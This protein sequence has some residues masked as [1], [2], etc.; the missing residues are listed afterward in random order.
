[1]KKLLF[2]YA[3]LS[4]L[5]TSP[6]S[7]MDLFKNFSATSF[8]VPRFSLL[9]FSAPKISVPSVTSGDVKQFMM[10]NAFMGVCAGGALG[11][12]AWYA[13]KPLNL[14][15]TSQKS[16]LVQKV[17]MP[18]AFGL[19]SFGGY[20]AMRNGFATANTLWSATAVGAF[21]SAAQWRQQRNISSVLSTQLGVLDSTVVDL[22]NTKKELTAPV[23]AL[24]E[25]EDS[26]VADYEH[27]KVTLERMVYAAALDEII[28]GKNNPVIKPIVTITVNN[29]EKSFVFEFNEETSY[30]HLFGV[31]LVEDFLK[32][33]PEL[34]EDY[35]FEQGLSADVSLNLTELPRRHIRR[36]SFSGFDRREKSE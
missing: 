4:A 18:V 11:L 32:E 22:K 26:N 3:L 35:C 7:G 29:S 10:S 1:M 31:N 5:I 6:A 23:D 15:E 27:K 30:N 9:N 19:G 20:Y 33:Q 12:A 16:S 8:S 28:R 34:L 36:H 21:F 14:G 2:S 13:L 24:T 25:E 17:S